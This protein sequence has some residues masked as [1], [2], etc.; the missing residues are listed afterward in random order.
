MMAEHS[1]RSTSWMI[2]A[3]NA[4]QSGWSESRTRP[5]LLMH[6]PI[7]SSCEACEATFGPITTPSTSLRLSKAGSKL[8][9]RRQRTS[10]QGHPGENEYCESFNG[11][12]RDELLNGKI[13]YSLHE[14]QIIIE[15]WRNHY[16]AKRPRSALGYR[17]PA[18]EAIIP[19]DQRPIMH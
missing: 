4:L 17:P 7:C 8:L 15:R 3:E 14:A 2:T 6:W 18:P 1:E 10:S 9:E 11:R 16:T 19:M 13:F 12:M 5:K